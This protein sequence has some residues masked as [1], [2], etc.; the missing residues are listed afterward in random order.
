MTCDR[1]GV[2][3]LPAAWADRAIASGYF[4]VA[5]SP[6][7]VEFTDRGGECGPQYFHEDAQDSPRP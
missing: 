1:G 3:G 6:L 5:G 2:Q 4:G 7:T